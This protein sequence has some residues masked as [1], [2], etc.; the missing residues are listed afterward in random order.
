MTEARTADNWDD[1]PTWARRTTDQLSSNLNNMALDDSTPPGIETPI[2]GGLDSH[3]PSQEVASII[4]A[5]IV[6]EDNLLNHR[7]TWFLTIQGLLY[8]AMAFAWD[9]DG[10]LIWGV[11]APLGIAI[12]LSFR[13][14]LNV[15][16]SAVVELQNWWDDRKP[17]DYDGPDIV[18][19]RIEVNKQIVWPWQSLPICICVSWTAAAII[20][21][22]R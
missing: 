3:W 18:G 4:R 15:G 7:M 11:L 22:F 17:V 6:H 13:F 16:P 14:T 8:A 5:M 20:R 1:R 12:G 21:V 9:K 2:S 10:T 19:R